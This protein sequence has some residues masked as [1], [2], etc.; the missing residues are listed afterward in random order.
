MVE[1]NDIWLLQGVVRIVVLKGG[2]HFNVIL[3]IPTAERRIGQLCLGRLGVRCGNRSGS[4]AFR[5][6][7]YGL[8]VHQIAGCHLYAV[9]LCLKQGSRSERCEEPSQTGR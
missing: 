2:G 8:V 7:C 6:H 1:C 4:F 3:V 5:S 9:V